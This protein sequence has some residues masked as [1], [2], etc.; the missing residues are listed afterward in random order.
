MADYSVELVEIVADADL[1]EL[2][3]SDEAEQRLALVDPGEL[4]ERIV[5]YYDECEAPVY[6]PDE[7][8]PRIYD[9]EFGRP[10][11]GMG[12]Q[13]PRLEHLRQI[14]PALLY[15]HRIEVTDPLLVALKYALRRGWNWPHFLR[16]AVRLH[17]RGRGRPVQPR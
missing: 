4:C 16:V 3:G 9:T 1:D 17:I 6:H 10:W 14:R 7:L 2:C 11:I 15:A 8:A 12:A 5:A 13:P